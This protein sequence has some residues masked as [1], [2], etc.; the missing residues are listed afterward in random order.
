M[1]LLALPQSAI[2]LRKGCISRGSDSD[3]RYYSGSEEIVEADWSMSRKGDIYIYIYTKALSGDNWLAKLK[4]RDG[5][6]RRLYNMMCDYFLFLAYYGIKS[7]PGIKEATG[8]H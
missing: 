5:K 4:V 8:L 7:N 6:Y 1:H 2:Y 3:S